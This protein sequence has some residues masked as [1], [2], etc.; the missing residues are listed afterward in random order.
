MLFS[1]WSLDA[2]AGRA[3]L[4]GAFSR[5]E[6]LCTKSLYNYVDLGLICV[7][8][9]DLPQKLRRKTKKSRCRQQK[10]ILGRSIEERPSEVNKREE[11][12]HWETDLVVGSKSGEDNVLLTLLERKTRQL[13]GIRLP[14]KRAESVIAA[15][16][17]I[18]D[19][20]GDHF[21]DVFKTIT[22]DNGSEFAKLSELEQSCHT[23]VY[24]NTEKCTETHLTKR[25]CCI[26]MNALEYFDS[27]ALFL[28]AS[29]QNL[30]GMKHHE[31]DC[32]N[33]AG[34]LYDGYGIR[35][36]RHL[37]CFDQ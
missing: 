19:S 16:Q 14:D 1:C 6:I 5:E 15:F 10:K 32:C 12:G 20:L 23:K 30:E 34:Y 17:S 27:N 18:R 24:K 25:V 3:L 9:I 21:S 33:A 26:K 7:K 11:F 8:N 29:L 28:A 37:R 4:D 13:R 31:K 2:C 35:R 22:T 36:M